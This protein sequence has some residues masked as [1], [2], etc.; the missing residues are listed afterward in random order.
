MV[1]DIIIFLAYPDTPV[2]LQ[3]LRDVIGKVRKTIS[4]PILLATHYPVPEDI[5]SQL[6]YFIYD[7]DDAPSSNYDVYYHY[8]IPDYLHIKT[9]RSLPYHGLSG[10]TSIKECATFLRNKAKYAHFFMYDT[11][12]DYLAYVALAKSKLRKAKWFGAEYHVPGQEIN[13]I[14]GSF[15]SFDVKWYDNHIPEVRTWEEYCSLAHGDKDNLL[16]ETWLHNYFADHRML[17]SCYF[18][19]AKE[20]DTCNLKC[21]VQTTGNTELGL[22]AYLSE[23]ADHRLIL[24]VHLYGDGQPLHI[25]LPVTVNYNGNIETLSLKN[26]AVYWKVIGKTG[27][28]KVS[29][30]GQTHEFVIDPKK[31]Y[32]QTV[33][34]FADG[35]IKCLR[36][37]E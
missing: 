12:M 7:R 30:S 22:K 25:H 23:L 10:Y 33:F 2:K 37:C 1:D 35:K 26:G 4:C 19:S 8:T 34:Q 18:V 5:I 3:L 14:C 36:E 11:I 24:F 13:G 27:H 6:D 32:T 17:S 20:M 29:S 16:G 9:L 28:V 15:Y 31:E 21:D